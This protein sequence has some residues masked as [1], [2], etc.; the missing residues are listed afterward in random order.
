[1]GIKVTVSILTPSV[2]VLDD[3]P[4]SKS[5]DLILEPILSLLKTLRIVPNQSKDWCNRGYKLTNTNSKLLSPK[6]KSLTHGQW[7]L[8]E[9]KNAPK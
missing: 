4:V 9:P 1:M 8:G 3:R 5:L 6:T 7:P 2:L